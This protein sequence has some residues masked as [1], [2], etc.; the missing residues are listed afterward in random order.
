VVVTPEYNH[1][2]PAALK[3]VIDSA[4]AEW[5]GKPAGFVSYGGLAGGLRAVEQLR[6][7]FAE[8]HVVTM[9]DGVSFASPWSQLDEAGALKAP[10]DASKA[11]ATMLA[12]LRWWAL[13][14]RTARL[15]APYAEI[16]A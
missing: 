3:F 13:A 10:P 4:Y 16:A 1:G 2:Y 8:L 15:A 7:V 6:P 5:N 14:L 12:Q 9:R 11:M